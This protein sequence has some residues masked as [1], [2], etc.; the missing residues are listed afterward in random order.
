MHTRMLLKGMFYVLLALLLFGGS[1][2]YAQPQSGEWIATTGFGEFAMT[3]D[4]TGERINKIRVTF[5]SFTCSNVTLGGTIISSRNPGWPITNNQFSIDRDFG[6]AQVNIAG[7]FSQSGQEA[8]GT[9]NVKVSSTDCGGTWSTIINS[10]ETIGDMVPEGYML[11]QNYPNPFN[12]TTKISFAVPQKSHVV[13]SVYNA[14]GQIVETLVDEE[15]SANIYEVDFNA[16]LLPS[17]IYF[18]TIRADNFNSVKK[19][20]LLK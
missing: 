16:A 15:L 8:S 6:S 14:I 11:S 17:G 9:W 10:I 12:P 3:V 20:L 1:N 18:Y 2:A 19:M 7:T 4:S 13:L 5:Q